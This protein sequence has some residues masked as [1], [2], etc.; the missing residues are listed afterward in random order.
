MRFLRLDRAILI[1]VA[2]LILWLA[3]AAWFNPFQFRVFAG[4]DLATFSANQASSSPPIRSLGIYYQKF[5]PVALTVIFFIAKWT[6]YDFRSIASISLAIHTANALLFF[7]LLCRTIK[8]PLALAAGLTV[9]ATFNRFTTY[10]LMQD[11]AIM[12]GVGVALLLLL[13]IKSLSFLE[14]PAIGRALVLVGL[15]ALLV[16]LHERYL[17][18]ALPLSLLAACHFKGKRR[19]AIVLGAGIIL[20]ALSYPAIKKPGSVRLFLLGQA[21][22]RSILD[23]ARLLPSSGAEH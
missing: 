6:N 13:L 1:A 17:A 2:A 22:V 10:L 20:T 21:A 8:L 4:D 16:Y 15:F 9:I 5:R 11:E 19:L 18:L 7:T 14:K 12:E 23:L 3:L